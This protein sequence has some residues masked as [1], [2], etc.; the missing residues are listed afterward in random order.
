MTRTRVLSTGILLL[1]LVVVLAACSK[2]TPQ[3]KT[4]QA[5]PAQQ[6]AQQPTPP[7]SAQ[8]QSAQTTT[9]AAP[10]A[11]APAPATAQPASTATGKPTGPPATEKHSLGVANYAGT[12]VTVSLNGQW[13]G[14]WDAHASA[15]LDSVVQGKN[16]L[17]VEL[18]AEPKNTITLEVNAARGGQTVNLLRLNFQ[19]KPAGTYNYYF[20]AR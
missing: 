8:S 11:P 18:Q 17:T 16:E 9:S 10:A 6:P 12:A 14:Q 20:V 19:G 3:P 5:A 13:V 15:P 1:A 2:E 7:P 4:Q